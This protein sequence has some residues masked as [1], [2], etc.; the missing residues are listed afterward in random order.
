MTGAVALLPAWLSAQDMRPAADET[1]RLEKLNRLYGELDSIERQLRGLHDIYSQDPEVGRLKRDA[2]KAREAAQAAVEERRRADAKAAAAA[3]EYRTIKESIARLERKRNVIR[4]RIEREPD[5]VEARRVRDKVR[6]EADAMEKAALAEYE[7]LYRAKLQENA[8]WANHDAEI[9]KLQRR[10]YALRH[11]TES[12]TRR[13]IQAPEAIEA[14][15]A[16]A[17]AESTYS[18]RLRE[19]VAGTVEGK[20]ALSVMEELERHRRGLERQLRTVSDR[21]A[22]EPGMTELGEAVAACRKRREETDLAYRRL[23]DGKLRSNREAVELR[24][25]LHG[26]HSGLRDRLEARLG[27]IQEAVG[28][29]ADVVAAYKARSEA[30]RAYEEARSAYDH[31]LRD[32]VVAHPDAAAPGAVLQ[33]LRDATYKVRELQ[34][35]ALRSNQQVMEAY[36]AKKQAGQ[37]LTETRKAVSEKA[38]QIVERDPEGARLLQ[39]K[40]DLENALRKLEADPQTQR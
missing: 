23:A 10:E 32:L 26:V 38:R 9:D 20:V 37:A 18:D 5:M 7:A 36:E 17:L 12:L 14:E 29:E 3:E 30:G 1:D 6:A 33:E 13:V 25:V 19:A 28:E 31:K 4:A 11:R 24:A 8:A 35:E 15:N 16:L 34:Q 21:V 22:E 40:T 27:E 39:R 2:A